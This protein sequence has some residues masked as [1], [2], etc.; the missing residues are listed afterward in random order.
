MLQPRLNESNATLER[1]KER[2]TNFSG[3]FELGLFIFLAKKSL[4]WV[5]FFFAVAIGF[6]WLYLRYSQSE[7]ESSAIMQI[8]NDNNAKMLNVSGLYN[9]EDQDELASAIEIIRSKVFL[10]RV[11]NKLPLETS[12]FAKGKI[13][14]SE[15]Y[16][17][18]PY[19]VGINIK[20][21]EIIGTHFDITFN[22]EIN[23]GEISYNL[24]GVPFRK[25][26]T[27]NK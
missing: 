12:Y 17:S 4:L 20:S 11:L 27:E 22:S 16:K 23:G 18:S 26:F 5:I 13:K 7:Y 3:D 2:L 9:M 6:S 21:E 19:N 8:N 10:K 1:Y 15:H 25:K 24:G 14:T